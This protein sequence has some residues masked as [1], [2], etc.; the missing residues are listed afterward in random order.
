MDFD[1]RDWL[2]ILG[3]VFVVGVLIHG[4]WRMRSGRN[5]LKMKLDKSFLN[6]RDEGVQPDELA[7]LKAELPNGGARIN[8]ELTQTSLDLGEINLEEDVPVLMEPVDIDSMDPVDAIDP[9]EPIEKK[10]DV[11]IPVIEKAPPALKPIV[12]ERPE[13]FVIVNVVADDHFDGQGL[14]ETLVELD[15]TF[16]EMDIFHRLGEDGCTEFSLANSVEPGTFVVAEMD[17]LQTPGIVL[18]MRVHDVHDPVAVFDDM[19]EVARK[20]KDEF[21]GELQDESRSAM[22]SQTIEHCRQGI[23]EFQYKYSA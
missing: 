11:A 16:G 13:K 20:L 17:Q 19:I 3:P 22:T 9:V 6:S 2:L 21:G 15:M 23:Q 12:T 1:L 4:Y 5:D 7:Y 10:A 8:V 14:L 18:F